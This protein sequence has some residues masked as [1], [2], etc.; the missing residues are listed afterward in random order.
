MLANNAIIIIS[1]AIIGG[2]ARR[3]ADSRS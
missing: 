1:I 2:A 3:C